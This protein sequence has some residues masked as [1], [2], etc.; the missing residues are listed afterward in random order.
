[1]DVRIGV[2]QTP[3]EIEVELAD[4]TDAD[5]LVRPDRRGARAEGACCGSP[6]GGAGGSASPRPGS[7]TSSSTP[8]ARIVG[9]A[10]A[11][12]S[13]TA[14]FAAPGALSGRRWSICSTAS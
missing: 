12:R 3:K 5:A 7:P 1:M 11:P 10:S 14:R 2:T 9:S 4:G 8:A 13:V 6:T